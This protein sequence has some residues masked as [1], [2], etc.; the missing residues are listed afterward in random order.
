MTVYF[1]VFA[2]GDTVIAVISVKF[3]AAGAASTGAF[4]VAV[5]TRL[6]V[7]LD[8]PH[9][10]HV[11]VASKGCYVLRVVYTVYFGRRELRRPRTL[12]AHESAGAPDCEDVGRFVFSLDRYVDKRWNC[13]VRSQESTAKEQF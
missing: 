7:A 11:V 13:Q 3:E 12:R 2:S 8:L 10:S 5:D 1:P 4:A 9:V 6:E